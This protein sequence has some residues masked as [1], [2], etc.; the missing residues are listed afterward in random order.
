VQTYESFS[1]DPLFTL[2]RILLNFRS[3]HCCDQ[4]LGQYLSRLLQAHNYI[5]HSNAF[6]SREHKMCLVGVFSDSK[7]II[8]HLAEEREHEIDP[9]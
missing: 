1:D 9:V 4:I 2:H 6:L 7:M 3:N 5:A 8:V